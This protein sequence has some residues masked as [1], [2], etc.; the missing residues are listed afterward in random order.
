MS[1]KVYTTMF[2]AIKGEIG[3]PER[4][5]TMAEL[6]ELT[7]EDREDFKRWLVEAGQLEQV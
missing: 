4:P 5:V 7:P 3:T 1:D 6:K 2:A